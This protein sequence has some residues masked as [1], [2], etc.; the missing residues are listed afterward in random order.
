MVVQSA[1]PGML[2]EQAMNPYFHTDE[3]PRSL[4]VRCSSLHFDVR[5]WYFWLTNV[6]LEPLERAPVVTRI[7]LNGTA[8]HA[9]T[10]EVLYRMQQSGASVGIVTIDAVEGYDD[11]YREQE[12]YP[13][14]TLSGHADG[15]VT[16]NGQPY[17]L[18]IKSINGGD[19]RH[20]KDRPMLKH[21][22]QAR[23]YY[24]LFQRPTLFLYESKDNQRYKWIVYHPSELDMVALHTKLHAI[25]E[26][27]V[28][29][30]VPDFC[31]QPTEPDF[32][33]YTVGSCAYCEFQQHCQRVGTAGESPDPYAFL[34]H[35]KDISK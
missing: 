18:E 30:T 2:L 19:W 17:V 27:V 5:Y 13:G 26:A 8:V 15:L 25:S 4:T 31:D 22:W 35:R 24:V 20:L 7:L 33:N 23:G 6:A 1:H 11:T 10:Q 3:F 32:P 12:V 28:S 16:I 29:Q 9:R 14:V 21:Q 34:L